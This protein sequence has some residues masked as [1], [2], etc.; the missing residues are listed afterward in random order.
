MGVCS[1]AASYLNCTLCIYAMSSAPVVFLFDLMM[2]KLECYGVVIDCLLLQVD[3]VSGTAC[4]ALW[5]LAIYAFRYL[6]VKWLL[7][8]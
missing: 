1:V 3:L 2:R 6:V 7:I 8:F 4:G 5:T